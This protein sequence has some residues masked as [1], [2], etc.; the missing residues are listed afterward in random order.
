MTARNIEIVLGGLVDAVRDRDPE[1]IA[2]FLA[3]D[4]VGG[5]QP[6]PWPAAITRSSGPR[7][8]GQHDSAAA[9]AT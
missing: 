5:R 6:R 8:R 3:P 7:E 2:G 1:R 9:A 4:L